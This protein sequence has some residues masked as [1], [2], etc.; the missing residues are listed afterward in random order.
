ML[1]GRADEK[2]IRPLIDQIGQVYLSVSQVA[3]HL[4]QLYEAG[5][6]ENAKGINV[7]RLR[8][9]ISQLEIAGRQ[10]LK[11]GF[12]FDLRDEMR[13]R[14]FLLEEGSDDFVLVSWKWLH[15]S[16]SAIQDE[17]IPDFY[18]DLADEIDSDET[19]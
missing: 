16:C 18:G 8:I 13:E 11:S 5:P 12:K 14:G 19:D 9:A 17:E 7:R 4:E 2:F 10:H 15:D 6:R 3:D 1:N